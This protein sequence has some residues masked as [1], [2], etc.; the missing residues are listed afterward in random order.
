MEGC[1]GTT[2]F[3]PKAEVREAPVCEVWASVHFLLQQVRAFWGTH[4]IFGYKVRRYLS[5]RATISSGY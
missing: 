3:W 2:S 1:A 5:Q 4:S